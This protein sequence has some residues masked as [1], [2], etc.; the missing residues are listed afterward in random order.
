MGFTKEECSLLFQNDKKRY[1]SKN[2]PCNCFFLNFNLERITP[3]PYHALPT[4]LQHYIRIV[5]YVSNHTLPENCSSC[6]LSLYINQVRVENILA[7][8]TTPMFDLTPVAMVSPAPHVSG[9]ACAVDQ[10]MVAA[11][12][13]VD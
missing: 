12:P 9:G 7:S 13:E 4:T 6:D 8:L 1:T 3:P 5:R 10:V 2:F 11:Q